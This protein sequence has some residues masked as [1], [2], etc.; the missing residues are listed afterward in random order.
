MKDQET[1][2]KFIEH[3]AQNWSFVRIAAELGVAKSTL[4][5]WSRKFRFEIH[6]RRAL[7]LDDL[8]DRVLGTVQSRVAGLAEKLSKVENELR[9]RGLSEV[10]TA[11]LYS[12]AASL[13]RQIERETGPIRLVTPTNAIPRDEY[14]EEVQ[15]WN[16]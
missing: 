11:Q 2:Q 8:H 15:E 6:N 13:R 4:T 9:Q 5:E 10:P 14:V 16:P 7:V 1:V 3:R 12:I